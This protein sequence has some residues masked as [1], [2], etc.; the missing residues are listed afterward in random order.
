LRRPAIGGNTT[1]RF[2]VFEGVQ[3]EYPNG[4]NPAGFR[5]APELWDFFAAHPLPQ[6]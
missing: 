6:R 4:A 1:L 2:G 3:H 5:A